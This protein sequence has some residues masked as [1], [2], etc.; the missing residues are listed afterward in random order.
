M[1]TFTFHQRDAV[2]ARPCIVYILHSLLKASTTQT[3]RRLV[4]ALLQAAARQNLLGEVDR[5]GVAHESMTL[6]NQ[7]GQEYA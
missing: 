6:V 1:F 3:H 4:T 5:S 2:R 7:Q